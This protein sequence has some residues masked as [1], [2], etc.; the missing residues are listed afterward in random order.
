MENI[1]WPVFFRELFRDLWAEEVCRGLKH[2]G[3]LLRAEAFLS[4]S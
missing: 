1:F 4:V 3:S 2:R